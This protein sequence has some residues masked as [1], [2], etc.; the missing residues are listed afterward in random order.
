MDSIKKVLVTGGAGYIGAH[1]AV[2]L[3]RSGYTPVLVDNLCNSDRTLLHGISET[4]GQELEFL[5]G[6]CADPQ[7]MRTVFRDHG[8]FIGVLHFAALKSV[9]ESVTE[10]LRYYRNNVGS[11]LTVLETMKEAGVWNLIFSSSC[12]V[13]GQPEIIPVNEQAPFRKAESPYGATKQV[14][15]YLLEDA[16]GVGFRVISLRYF[17]P[18]GAHPQGHLGEMPVGIPNNLVPYVTQTAAGIRKQLTVFGADYPT[19]DGSCL[20]D[21]IHVV[22]VASAH[23]QAL[24]YLLKRPEAGLFEP[25]NLGTGEGVTVLD[26]IKTFQKATGVSLNYVIGPRRPGDVVKVYA[27]ASKIRAAMGWEPKFTLHE[28]MAH[29]WAW[30][31]K[32][33]GLP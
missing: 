12:T 9:G 6:D 3:F 20:R 24:E 23:V 13:Y 19:P 21:F 33:S 25:F 7:F 2:E 28:A 15:E 4:L 17:N 5:Q 32:I 29:A 26:L 16:S 10:P 1:T 31:K 8:P 18:V 11:L 22:D 14:G 27:D 30:Q